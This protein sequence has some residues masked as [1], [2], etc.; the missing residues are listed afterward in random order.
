[1]LRQRWCAWAC[2]RT[3]R[4]PSS[5]GARCLRFILLFWLPPLRASHKAHADR[6]RRLFREGLIAVN[7]P[8]RTY[9]IG[10]MCTATEA[11]KMCPNLVIQHVATWREGDDSW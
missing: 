4:S 7:Y 6:P 2:P 8:A 3:S 1:M 9:G 10:R 5:N 11:K